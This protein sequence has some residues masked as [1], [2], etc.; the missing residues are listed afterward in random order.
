MLCTKTVQEQTTTVSATSLNA[1]TVAIE[2]KRCECVKCVW[3]KLQ[4]MGDTSTQADM[5]AATA[6][7]AE[8]DQLFGRKRHTKE[9]KTPRAGAVVQKRTTI[10]KEIWRVTSV[11]EGKSSS[12]NTYMREC[13]FTLITN[14]ELYLEQRC[15]RSVSAWLSSTLVPEP[16][17]NAVC[18]HSSSLHIMQLKLILL[19]RVEQVATLIIRG[20]YFAWSRCIWSVSVLLW[21]TAGRHHLNM[22]IETCQSCQCL[23]M[24][25]SNLA[26]CS[27]WQFGPRKWTFVHEQG[28]TIQRQ[29]VE[30]INIS[31]DE[32][33]L[34][35]LGW[36]NETSHFSA[37]AEDPAVS[38]LR[39]K[40]YCVIIANVMLYDVN[41]K[42]F[43][44]RSEKI[45]K[46]EKR[47]VK[48]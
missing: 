7:T 19:M 41:C 46:T 2:R 48:F 6:H 20:R 10:K 24:Q 30:T 23:V 29:N 37:S 47:N 1:G 14:E 21:S 5:N 9:G 44:W 25:R 40:H 16:L 45:I 27:T 12:S 33:A 17:R 43:R 28:G 4:F 39:L 42:I 18:P 31:A 3:V 32:E 11:L 15:I 34:P 26:Q 8:V 13:L 36:K 35:I 22:D 38:M